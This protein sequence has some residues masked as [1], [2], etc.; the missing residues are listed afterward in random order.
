MGSECMN[1]QISTARANTCRE[2]SW[3]H[4]CSLQP[5]QMEP[6]TVTVAGFE[7]QFPF[8]PYGTQLAFCSRMLKALSTN[9]NA[10]LESPTGTGKTTSL[11]C[12]AMAWQYRA[13]HQLYG[14]PCTIGLLSA[15]RQLPSSPVSTSKRT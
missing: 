3:D 10:L 2:R 11:L 8:K 12:S 14:L 15:P 4:G 13:K 5:L 6:T 9:S 7:V 1:R